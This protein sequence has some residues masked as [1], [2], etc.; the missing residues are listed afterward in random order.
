MLCEGIQSFYLNDQRLRKKGIYC[1]NGQVIMR[2]K[3]CSCFGSK[4]GGGSCWP[5]Q[6]YSEDNVD[7]IW[8]MAGFGGCVEEGVCVFRLRK[9]HTQQVQ[10]IPRDA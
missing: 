4:G 1:Y 6:M 3:E 10:K 8:P 2:A 7:G 9:E 5:K